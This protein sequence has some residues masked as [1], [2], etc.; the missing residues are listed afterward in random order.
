MNFLKPESVYKL[1]NIRNELVQMEDFI[2]FQLIKRSEYPISS[3]LYSSDENV[4]PQL[5]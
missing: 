4:R 5:T 2:I 3:V 1:D